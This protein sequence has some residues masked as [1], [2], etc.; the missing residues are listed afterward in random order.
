MIKEDQNYILNV[1]K[2]IPIEIERG[3][4]CYLFDQNNTPYLDMFGGIAVNSLGYQH[5]AI[6]EAFKQKDQ[7]IHLSNYFASKPVVDLA[8]ILVDHSFAS[9]VFFTNSGTEA[10]EASIKLARK[11]GRSINPDKI[12]FIAIDK[13]FHGRS[14]G[15]MALTGK[16]I[17]HEMFSP[18]L[19]GVKHIPINDIDA[20]E[21]VVSKNTCAI[22]IEYIQGEGGVYLLDFEYLKRIHE[23]K[24]KYNFIIVA[25]EIQTGLMR[26]GKPFAYMHYGLTPDL[27]TIA[28][29]LGGGIP[30]GAL[31]VSKNYEN[32]FGFGDHGSTF[33]GN[34]LACALGVATLNVLFQSE[35]E[36]ELN[37]KSTWFISEL[38]RLK[39]AYPTIIKD[40]RGMGFMIGIEMDY[41]IESVKKAFLNANILI[42]VTNQNV[43]RLLPPLVMSKQEIDRF[44]HTFELLLNNHFGASS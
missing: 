21:N 38:M 9:K 2:R 24:N 33:G 27:L 16:Q 5:E 22:F 39:N 43:I 23:L 41:D 36:A 34:P 10:I 31:L 25:D 35:F 7:Y 19:P 3:Q 37:L 32:V 40:V 4:G 15:G 11:W 28:K 20:L 42:N 8:K 26:T 18:I 29:S 44:I 1:Y 6:I 13:G 12:E 14:S 30:L 17:Y